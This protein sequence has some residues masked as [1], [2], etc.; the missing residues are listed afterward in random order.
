[1]DIGGGDRELSRE[2]FEYDRPW[3][4]SL[5]PYRLEDCVSTF[6]LVF[7]S[8]EYDR[9]RD[10]SPPYLPVDCVSIFDRVV[11]SNTEGVTLDRCR[12]PHP[13]LSFAD[14]C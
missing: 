11:D 2:R 1:M 12:V 4:R 14:A 9:F 5:S 13:P 8:V 10:R 3:D 7:D 6:D